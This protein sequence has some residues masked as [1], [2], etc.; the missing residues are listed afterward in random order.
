[1]TAFLGDARFLTTARRRD[2]REAL[3]QLAQFGLQVAPAKIQWRRVPPED[4]RESWKKHFPPLRIG[5]HLIVRPSWT[6]VRRQPGQAE[7]ILDPGLSFGTGQHPTTEFCLREIVRLRPRS[8]EQTAALLDVGT[9]SGILAL[10]AA[11]LGY[12]PVEAFDFDPDCVVV[13]HANARRNR[14]TARVKWSRRDVAK[15]PARPRRSFAVVCANLT[16]DLLDRHATRLVAH[17]APGGTL[18]LAGILAEEFATLRDRFIALGLEPARTLRR[19]EW[20]SGSF[21]RI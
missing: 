14:L 21:R 13:A 4:W 2:L 3:D 11:R 8:T 10:A 1:M 19:R 5:K 7:L 12:R 16:A 18:I 6:Q 17:V 9:G 15:L 20:Q